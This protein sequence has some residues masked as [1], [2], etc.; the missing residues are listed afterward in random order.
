MTGWALFC[1]KF[2][3][4]NAK[5]IVA[6]DAH[7]MK[8]GTGNG[9]RFARPFWRRIG[10]LAGGSLSGHGVILTCERWPAKGEGRHPSSGPGHL[11]HTWE[12]DCLKDEV[13]CSEDE[14]QQSEFFG[15]FSELCAC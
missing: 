14:R 5:H 8:N 11:L 12:A 15:E 3:G 13:S 4:G 10:T 9:R 6:L 7:A 2:I 1:I